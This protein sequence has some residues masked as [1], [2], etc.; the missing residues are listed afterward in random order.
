MLKRLLSKFKGNNSSSE[1][2]MSHRY[3]VE[4]SGLS[5]LFNLADEDALW[6]LVAYMEQLSEEEYV[7]ELSDRWLLTWDELYRLSADEEHQTSLPLLGIPE[8]KPLKVCLAGN[9]SLSDPEFSVYTRDWKESATD[10]SV[11]IEKRGR[12]LTALKDNF[13]DL[14]EL[15]A[16]FCPATIS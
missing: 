5:F 4:E 6:P 15:A 16:S 2:L 3:Q 9:G 12:Y 7:V 8:V 10:R 13:T 1:K 14:G 11:Q